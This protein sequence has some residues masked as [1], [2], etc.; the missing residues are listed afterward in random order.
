MAYDANRPGAK[1]HLDH[2]KQIAKRLIE[3]LEKA[4]GNEATFEPAGGYEWSFE[5]DENANLK[6]S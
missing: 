1:T 5:V 6:G 2:A 4:G 3:R